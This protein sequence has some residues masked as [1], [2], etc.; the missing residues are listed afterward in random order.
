MLT[1]LLDGTPEGI[2]WFA[3]QAPLHATEILDILRS[4]DGEKPNLLALRLEAQ[5]IINKMAAAADEGA[6]VEAWDAQYAREVGA[7]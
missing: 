1:K 5:T 3:D 7:L 4:L 2:A 6:A